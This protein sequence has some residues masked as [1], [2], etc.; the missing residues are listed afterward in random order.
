[1]AFFRYTDERI[2]ADSS[3]R[4]YRGSHNSIRR[5]GRYF[6]QILDMTS[7]ISGKPSGRNLAGGQDRKSFG[8]PYRANETLFRLAPLPLILLHFLGERLLIRRVRMYTRDD[9]R[10]I[11][12]GLSNVSVRIASPFH[13]LY[14]VNDNRPD[15]VAIAAGGDAE[16]RSEETII[17][18]D[19]ITEPS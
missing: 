16:F 4:A 7:F 15:I 1:M 17:A 6:S 5:V 19:S 3:I 18:G 12:T 10:I 14:V 8:A 13:A 2:P 11:E 9:E